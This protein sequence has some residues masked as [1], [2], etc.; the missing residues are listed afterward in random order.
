MKVLI[1]MTGK[2]AVAAEASAAL[3][4]LAVTNIE[5]QSSSTPR[6]MEFAIAW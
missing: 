5:Y 6:S 4:V 1:A 2:R 3:H